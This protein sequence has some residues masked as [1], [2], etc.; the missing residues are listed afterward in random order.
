MSPTVQIFIIYVTIYYIDVLY[1]N[2][3]SHNIMKIVICKIQNYRFSFIYYLKENNV[4]GYIH[5]NLV[6]A[7]LYISG[8]IGKPV[9][10]TGILCLNK[11]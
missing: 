8:R 7:F 9:T 4:R 1:K 3:S 11:D 6:S 5:T 2:I 10:V